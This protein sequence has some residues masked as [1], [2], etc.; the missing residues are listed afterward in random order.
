MMN[1]GFEF[2]SPKRGLPQLKEFLKDNCIMCLV[3]YNYGV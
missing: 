1:R 2:L 3:I